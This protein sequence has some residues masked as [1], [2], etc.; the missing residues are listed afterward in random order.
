MNPDWQTLLVFLI[1]G[2]TA[3]LFLR[4][5]IRPKN[6]CDHECGCGAGKIKRHRVIEKILK[7][8][9]KQ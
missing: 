2:L 7:N 6:R 3:G 9:R 4:N 8:E 1:V 5:L